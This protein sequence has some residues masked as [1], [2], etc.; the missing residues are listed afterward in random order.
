MG[1]D[2]GT[3]TE[4]VYIID[5]T[6]INQIIDVFCIYKAIQKYTCSCMLL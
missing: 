1:V 6:N 4:K 5:K 3:Q 2:K